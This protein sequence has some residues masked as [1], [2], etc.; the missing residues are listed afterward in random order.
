MPKVTMMTSPEILEQATAL[1]RVAADVVYRA[2]YHEGAAAEARAN[3]HFRLIKT[4]SGFTPTEALVIVRCVE[5][6]IA[7]VDGRSIDVE[8]TVRDYFAADRGEYI[9]RNMMGSLEKL[10]GLLSRLDE[11]L[12]SLGVPDETRPQWVQAGMDFPPG[13]GAARQVGLTHLD[14]E[15]WTNA[16]VRADAFLAHAAGL[17]WELRSGMVDLDSFA[18]ALSAAVAGA[19]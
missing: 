2:E 9:E 8:K 10:S 3:E 14:N 4:L 15:A 19:E 18:D 13:D 17:P 7:V 11:G 6:Q 16:A 5:A 12:R 1:E